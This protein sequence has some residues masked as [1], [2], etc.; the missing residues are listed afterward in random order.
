MRRN[1]RAAASNECPADHARHTNEKPRASGPGCVLSSRSV[2]QYRATTGPPQLNNQLARAVMANTLASE[3]N[4][5]PTVPSVARNCAAST[6]GAP[7]LATGREVVQRNDLR[8]ARH[9]GATVGLLE[10]DEHATQVAISTES[11]M[12]VPPRDAYRVTVR[13]AAPSQWEWEIL[14]DGRPLELRLREGLFNSERA[15]IAAGTA[16]LH[17][18]LKFLDSEPV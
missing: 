5:L 2:D 7:R 12:T 3:L 8:L 13:E 17:E 14:R 18:F 1:H 4:T 10:H 15:A 9:D 6:E 11:F 16:A